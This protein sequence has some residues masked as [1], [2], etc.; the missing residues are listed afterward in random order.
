M[1]DSTNID[2]APAALPVQLGPMTVPKASEVLANELRERIL[3]GE[4]PQGTAL[5]AER[6]LVAQTRMSRTTVREALLTL[7]VQ[8]LLSV[9]RGRA[10]GAFVQRPAHE[11]VARS[12]GLLIQGRSI[13]LAALMECRELIEP[14]CAQLAA[15]HRTDADLARLAEPDA[16]LWDSGTGTSSFLEAHIDWHLAVAAAG[17]NELLSAFTTAT[18]RAI[19]AS[20]DV[21]G[22]ADENVRGSTVRAHRAITEAIR[23]QDPVGAARHMRVHLRASAQVIREAEERSA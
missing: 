7:E 11:S 8:G 19:F 20:A 3:R 5:P 13:Q 1:T 23:R 12:I 9:R 15:K 6:E 18:S 10:G 4:F 14:G 2:V 17:H 16:A 22:F 21:Q